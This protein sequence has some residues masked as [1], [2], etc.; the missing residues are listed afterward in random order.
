MGFSF[1]QNEENHTFELLMFPLVKYLL[2][3]LYIS[4][5][6]SCFLR[7]N[8]YDDVHAEQHDE[9]NDVNIHQTPEQIAKDMAKVQKKQQRAY[10]KQLK[11]T[12]RQMDKRNK[13]KIEGKIKGE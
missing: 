5:F 1:Q 2:M 4:F 12:K 7:K 8:N 13:K 6:C 9:I 11:K 3:V 10:R